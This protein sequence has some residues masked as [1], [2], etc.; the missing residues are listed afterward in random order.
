MTAYLFGYGTNVVYNGW[1]IFFI[2][3]IKLLFFYPTVAKCNSFGAGPFLC[4]AFSTT[5]QMYA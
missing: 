2:K 5:H 4:S 1:R 3:I